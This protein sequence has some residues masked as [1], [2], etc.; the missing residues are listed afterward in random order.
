LIFRYDNAKHRPL[1]P[2]ENHKHLD[3]DEIVQSDTPQFGQVLGE[4]MDHLL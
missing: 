3:S 2:F 4:I 1:L